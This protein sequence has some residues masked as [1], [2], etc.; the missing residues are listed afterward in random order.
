MKGWMR[1]NALILAV[2]LALTLGMPPLYMAHAVEAEPTPMQ[3][4][5]NALMEDGNR[6]WVLKTLIRR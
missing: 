5:L 1:P 2:I 6:N 4:A 3:D